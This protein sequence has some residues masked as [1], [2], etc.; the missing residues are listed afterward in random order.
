[1]IN[2]Y[3]TKS[4]GRR[5]RNGHVTSTGSVYIIT[6]GD[7]TTAHGED[8]LTN[9]GEYKHQSGGADVELSIL[10]ILEKNGI[11]TGGGYYGSKYREYVNLIEL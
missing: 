6:R 2:V 1:M 3:F 7:N 4:E 9:I 11:D 5:N 10:T 8:E